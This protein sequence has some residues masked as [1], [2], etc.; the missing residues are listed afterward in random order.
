MANCLLRLLQIRL[1]RVMLAPEACFSVR[2]CD[3]VFIWGQVGFIWL[4]DGMLYCVFSS[5]KW[6]AGRWI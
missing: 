4:V 6:I 2:V 3:Q 1:S 5:E